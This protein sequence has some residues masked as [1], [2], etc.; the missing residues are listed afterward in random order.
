MVQKLVSMYFNDDHDDKRKQREVLGDYLCDGWAVK[1]I[2]PVG[3]GA[4]SGGESST[5][6]YVAG[7]ALVLLEKP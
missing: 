2:T 7:W 6:G 4:G 1:S 3:A 5:G